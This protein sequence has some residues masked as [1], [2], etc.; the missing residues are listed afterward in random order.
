MKYLARTP[1]NR[2]GHRTQGNEKL[3]QPREAQ[4]DMMTECNCNLGV[5]V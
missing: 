4:G 5:W 3:S 2:Q 1:Q